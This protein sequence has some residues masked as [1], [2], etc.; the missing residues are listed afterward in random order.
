[1]ARRVPARCPAADRSVRVVAPDR[2]ARMDDR[3][4][5]GTGSA[6][7]AS[8]TQ[9]RAGAIA[10]PVSRTPRGTRSGRRGAS[11]AARR[12]CARLADVSRRTS[13]PSS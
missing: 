1:M 5:C 6:W 8:T 4:P 9:P 3:T 10:T 2:A 11:H 7:P 13:W 12:R